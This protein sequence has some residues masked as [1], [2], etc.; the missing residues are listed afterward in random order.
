MDASCAWNYDSRKFATKFSPTLSSGTT[1]HIRL[2]PKSTLFNS[3][4]IE[5][6]RQ[7]DH[8]QYL[9]GTWAWPRCSVNNFI[10]SCCKRLAKSY[11]VPAGKRQLLRKRTVHFEGKTKNYLLLKRVVQLPPGFKELTDACDTVKSCRWT[12]TF[13]RNPFEIRVVMAG[14][15]N[16]CIVGAK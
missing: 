3:E 7:R 6:H 16:G 10:A 11:A 5:P 4:Y 2:I 9:V 12:P 15:R 1:F 8:I 14:M 13:R